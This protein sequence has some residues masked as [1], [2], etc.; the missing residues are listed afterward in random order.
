MCFFLHLE[1]STLKILKI[2]KNANKLPFEIAPIDNFH[3]IAFSLLLSKQNTFLPYT[4]RLM[5][6]GMWKCSIS[7]CVASTYNSAVHS[8]DFSF[9]LHVF[10]Q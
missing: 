2:E 7:C 1:L 5:V 10:E 4:T 3:Q 6:C 9:R 8:I